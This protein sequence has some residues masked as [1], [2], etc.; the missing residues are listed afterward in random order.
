VSD[1]RS[2]AEAIDPM[3]NSFGQ[4]FHSMNSTTMG[5]EGMASIP[6]SRITTIIA[7]SL[8]S[9]ASSP[10]GNYAL[11]GPELFTGCEI[12]VEKRLVVGLKSQTGWSL[13]H[14]ATSTPAF[15]RGK[16]HSS[17]SI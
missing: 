10:G 4:A 14:M 11:C 5:N 15:I 12:A 2:D 16:W 17:A 1:A 9:T 6:G 8:I 3:E 7:I 13:A